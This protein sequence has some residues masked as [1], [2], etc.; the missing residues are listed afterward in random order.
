MTILVSAAGGQLGALVVEA[1]L[2]RGVAPDQ[3]VAGA[4]TPSKV[5]HFADRGVRVAHIDYDD[6][7]T[8]DAALD[9]VDRLLLVSG[10][11][12]GERYPGHRNV[13]DAV[14]RHGGVEQLVYTSL[15]K[16]GQD[17]F[18]LGDEHV[19]TEQALAAS[20]IPSVV[21]RNDW[22][23]ENAVPDV[24]RAAETGVIAASVGDGRISYASRADYAEAAAVVLIDGGHIGETYE[25]AGD[26]AWSYDE[27]AALA[28]RLLGRPVAYERLS[29]EQHIAALEAAGL[30]AD[31]AAFVAGI[32]DGIRRGMLDVDDKT[33]ARLLGRPTTPLEETLRAALAA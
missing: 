21:L 17:V 10:S 19:Q 6:P 16:V 18:P 23:S 11:E 28:S 31:T 25:L 29:T 9:G 15:S 4:R 14:E 12:I 24:T 32:D 5:E 26:V 27:L 7:A 1:L 22:Y 20:S 8:L 2:A 30:D 33:L 3:I 13:I